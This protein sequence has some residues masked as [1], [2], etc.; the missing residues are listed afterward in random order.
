M[1]KLIRR[2]LMNAEQ[3]RSEIINIFGKYILFNKDF[4]DY[5]CQL[6][7]D[8]YASLVEWCAQCKADQHRGQTPNKPHLQH[9]Y[10]FFRKIGNQVRVVLIKEKNRDFIEIHLTGHRQ[11]DDKRKELGFKKSSYYGS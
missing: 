7:E 4:D 10:V 2:S 11:Y 6:K 1:N 9:L 5:A 8:M 3:L